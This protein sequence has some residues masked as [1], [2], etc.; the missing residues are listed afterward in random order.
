[1]KNTN[2]LYGKINRGKKCSPEE[3]KHHHK[4]QNFTKCVHQTPP[5]F[6]RALGGTRINPRFKASMTLPLLDWLFQKSKKIRR[7]EYLNLSPEK[8]FYLPFVR[9]NISNLK[10]KFKKKI[11]KNSGSQ[12]LR[13]EILHTLTQSVCLFF[14]RILKAAGQKYINL[15]PL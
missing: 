9:A 10:I 7:Y 12:C 15:S 14:K 4:I 11:K 8:T 6:R 2:T 5:C 13:A 3:K 1:M